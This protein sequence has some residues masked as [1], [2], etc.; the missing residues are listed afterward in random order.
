MN[1]SIFQT[2][3]GVMNKMIDGGYGEAVE[4]SVN[5]TVDP[6]FGARRIY[7][8]E[9]EEI[10][11]MSTIIEGDIDHTHKKWVFVFKGRDYVVRQIVPVPSVGSNEPNHYEIIVT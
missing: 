8:N 6:V 3:T 10:T 4:S 11:G 1:F 9:N 2:E 7:T 5:V